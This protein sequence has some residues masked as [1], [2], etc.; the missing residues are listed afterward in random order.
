MMSCRYAEQ[1]EDSKSSLCW[2][3]DSAMGQR[4]EKEEQR[5]RSFKALR[6]CYVL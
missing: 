1:I 3:D 5:P 6:G 2:I 4:E